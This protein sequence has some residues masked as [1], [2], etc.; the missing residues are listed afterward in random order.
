MPARRPLEEPDLAVVQHIKNASA[1]ME[2]MIADVLD[3]ARGRLSGGIPVKPALANMG[4]ICRLAV[5][6]ANASGHLPITIETSGD[7]NGA[8]D[9]DRIRQALSNLL[10]NAQSY[11]GGAIEVRAWESEDRKKVFTT[12]TNHGPM[13]PPEQI[14]TLFDPFK[15]A[16]GAPGRGLGLGLYIVAE[17]ARAHGAV[18]SAKSSADATVFSIEWPRIPFEDTPNRP[19]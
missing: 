9:H 10:R 5:E 13:I 2:R 18:C 15:R 14:L 19:V 4:E 7:L 11:G 1:R 16:A 17:I 12:V 8:F 3:F 6:E